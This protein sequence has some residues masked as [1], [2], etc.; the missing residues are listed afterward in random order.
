MDAIKKWL[1]GA[2]SVA[3]IAGAPTFTLLP[4]S[5]AGMKE[6]AVAADSEASGEAQYVGAETCNGCHKDQAAQWRQ[7]HHAKAMQHASSQT[8]LGDFNNATLPLS[9]AVSRFFKRDG[10]YFVHTDGPGNQPSE[11]EIRY[12]FGVSPLQQYLVELP[13]GKL[14]ALGTAWDAR[15]K[16][17]GGQRWFHLYPDEKLKAGDPLHWSGRDQNWNFMC[18][19]C[20]STNLQRNYDPVSDSYQTTWSDINVAC[21]ACH[22]AG[23]HH[24][25]WAREGKKAALANSGFA[26]RLRSGNGLS[27][28]FS[29][30]AQKIATPQPEAGVRGTDRHDEAETCFPCHSRRQDLS[31][32]DKVGQLFLDRYQPSLLERGQYH[33]DGQIDGEVFEFGAFTQSKMYR[34]GVTCSNCHLPH[35]LKLRAEGN[36]LCGQCH[37]ASHYERPEHHHHQAGTAGAACVNCH[38]P[39]KTYMGVDQRRD[40]G[41]H[42][43]RPDVSKRFQ[44][45]NACAQCHAGKSPQWATAALE[46]WGAKTGDGAQRL[47]SGMD[48]AWS[49]SVQTEHLLSAVAADTQL[50]SIQQATALS[51]LPSTRSPA[52]LGQLVQALAS[53]S[54]IVRLGAARGLANLE[55]Q[56]RAQIGL[57]LLGDPL[58]AIRIEAA[59]ALADIPRQRLSPAQNAGLDAAIEE[60]IGA[61][62]AAAERPESHVNLAQ[63]Y[64]RLGRPDDA[65]KELKTSMRLAPRFIPALVNLADLHRLRKQDGEGEKLLRDAIAIDPGSASPVFALG[66]LKVRQS[67]RGEALELLARA[68]RLEP[69]DAQYA[70]VY[71]MGLHDGGDSRK[72]LS[73]IGNARKHAPED[74][75][76]LQLQIGVEQ[77]LGLKE[78]AAHQAELACLL[79]GERR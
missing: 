49:G 57:G 43:P 3:L 24:A 31:R 20:H 61:E 46:R 9:G 68:T 75:A 38:M 26:L 10:K 32:T 76:L 60:A 66:L 79:G 40:H 48:A 52:I 51:L 47:A 77:K 62:L 74:G 71:A 36:A 8:V 69:R 54:P 18:A 56:L 39:T 37:Q 53:P 5:T 67:K 14:Q 2:A 23:S 15:P 6:V 78:A 30:S 29:S 25:A 4:K 55:P 33:V 19:G 50:A 21:E 70:Y 7:S 34:A 28:N 41:F 59:R 1:F 64:L 11:Y 58:R 16:A 45:P 44:T 12:T 17:Q 73:V 72:A 13:G 42:V 22:G 65:E 63:L 27:W 35:S